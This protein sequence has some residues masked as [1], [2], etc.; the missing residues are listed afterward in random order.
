MMHEKLLLFVIRWNFVNN[1]VSS[2]AL[3]SH[4]LDSQTRTHAVPHPPFSQALVKALGCGRGRD[5][6]QPVG[7]REG[8]CG[9]EDA[10]PVTHRGHVDV[11]Y[12]TRGYAVGGARE[13]GGEAGHELLGLRVDGRGGDEGAA[14]GERRKR[15]ERQDRGNG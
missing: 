11:P 8:V 3:P 12:C 6:R 1:A 2:R 5:E 9:C 4:S 14:T 15:G 10:R 13:A 7:P